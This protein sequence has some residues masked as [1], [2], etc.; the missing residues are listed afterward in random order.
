MG[1]LTVMTMVFFLSGGHVGA[2]TLLAPDQAQCEAALPQ[3]ATDMLG[4]RITADSSD[5][6]ETILD[7]QGVCNTFTK[8][9][10]AGLT[11]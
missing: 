10:N 5:E 2:N 4:R 6:P 8:G 3:L 1:T 7:V 9:E 11:K